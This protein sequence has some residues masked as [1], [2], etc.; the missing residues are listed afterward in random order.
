MYLAAF[1]RAPEKSGLDYWL[2]QI[3]SGKSFES[4]LETVFSLDIVKA[5]YPSAMT[6]QAFVTAIYANV[7]GRSP[8]QQGLNYWVSQLENKLGR[9]KLVMDMINAG[10]S[11]P[12]GTP[13]KAYIVNRLSVAEYAADQ[14]N[15]QQSDLSPIYLKSILSTVNADPASVT[16]AQK[17]LDPNV[18]G[19][20]LGAPLNALNVV[21]ASG[22]ISAPE[23]LAGVK[24]ILDLKGTNA[25]VG[26]IV[27][28]LIDKTSF[29]NPVS[30]ILNDAD[31]K[32][33]KVSVTIPAT[34]NWGADGLHTLSAY[35]KNS[36]GVQG[37]AGGDLVI[38]LNQ[39]APIAPR[40]PLELPAASKGING[41]EKAAGIQVKVDLA[42]TN[43]AVGDLLE[44]LI[45]GKSFSP[46]ATTVLKAS[47]V[48]AGV[49]STMIPLNAVWGADGSKVLEARIIDTSGNLGG[50][51]G[52]LTVT[53]DLTAPLPFKNVLQID[54]AVGGLSA[55]E[56]AADIAVVANLSGMN[57]IAGDS[58]ELLVD[59]KPFAVSTLHVLT[60]EEINANRAV[61]RIAGGDTAWGITD[62]TKVVTA[63]AIDAAGNTGVA[64]GDFKVVVDTQAP[65]SQNALIAI[66]A[67][68]NGLNAAEINAGVDVVVNLTG[69]NATAGDVVTLLLG[70]Q[71]IGSGLSTTL[72]ATQVSSKSVTLKIPSGTVWGVDG[73][74]LLT[75]TIRD[76]AG[77]TGSLGS[78]FNLIVDTVAP[79]K[80]GSAPVIAVSASNIN[81]A[82]KTAGVVANIDIASTG[83][84]VGDKV[85]ILLNG[86]TMTVPVLQTIQAEDLINGNVNVT[87][88]SAAGWGSDGSKTFTAR[89][90]DVA[91]NVGATSDSVVVN[92][93]TTAPS[94]PTA[95]LQVPANSGGGITPAERAAGVQVTVSLT[96]TSAVAG[97]QVE[98]LIG[99]AS[100]ATP[101][102]KSLTAA[103]V[104][105][106]SVT[107]TI[108]GRDGWGANG[109]KDLT[110][111]FID[112][113]GNPGTA[114]GKVTVNA[115]PPTPVSSPL[116]IAAAVGG[117]NPAEKAGG[118]IVTASLT[119]TNVQ[120]GDAIELLIDGK[121]FANSTLH[122]ISASEITAGVATLSITGGDTAWGTTDGDRTIAAR[123]IDL[124]G[125]VGL[126]GGSLK[127]TIDSVAP[128]S[129]NLA[130]TVPAAL[131]GLNAAELAAGVDVTVNL[132]GTNAA[133]G[134]V[135]TLLLGG[136]SFTPL[137]SVVLSAA[138]VTAKSAVV[139][140]PGLVSWGADGNKTLSAFIT[141]A[142]G[143]QGLPGGA[144][145]VSLDTGVPNAPSNPIIIPVASNSINVSEKQSGV[146]VLVDLTG[147]NAV[148]GDKVEVLIDGV[149]FTTPVVQTISATDI[150]N[151]TV[152][153][154]I[155]NTANWGSD[156][157]KLMSARVTDTVGNL[158]IANA[159]IGVGL[160]LTAPLAFKNVL[161]IDAAVGGLSAAEKAADIA[162]VANLSGMNL[163]AGDSLELL[164]D[165]KPFAV[166][167][168]HVLTAE[169]INANRAVL[170]IAGGDTAWGITDGTKVVT[171]RAIDAAG[172]T[173]VAGG[174]FKVVVD[175]Q[176]PASQNA[177]IA[178]AAAANGLNAAEIN[179]GVDVVVNL[180]GTNATAGDVVT[181]LLGG[182]P[183]GSGLSTTLTATQV[184]SK[185][186]TLKIP[187]GTVWGVD[188]SKL[189]TA[190]IRD[191]AGNTGS[192]GSEFN[193]IVDTVAPGKPGSAPVIAVSASNINAAEKTA[194][195]VAN[196]DIASTGALVGDKVEILLNGSTMTVP[197]LQ[198]IQAED[199]INGNVNVTIPSA[200]GWGSDGSKTFTARVIDVAGNVGA[201]SDSV[202]VNLDT[203]APSGPTATLQV[204]ANSGGGIT[205]AERAAG[206]Q[207]TVSLTGTSAVAGEQVEILIGGASFATPVIKSLTAAEVTAKS[208]TLTIGGRDGWGANGI[209]DLTAR[210][211]DASGNP[212]TASGKVTVNAVPPTPVSSPLQIA[213]AVGGINPAEKAGGMIVTA[214][215]TNTN[216]QAGDAI[217][218]LI[219]GKPFAN[220]TLHV[221]SASEI[222][223]GVATLSITG[224]D[225]AWGT[226]D[227]DRTIAARFIDLSGNVGL[228][229]GSLK[230]TID[231][232]APTSQNLALT[233]PAA[234]N[235]L[236]AAELAAGVDVT[237]NL[238]GTNAAAG[239][240]VTLLLGGASFTPLVSVVLSAAQV[241]AKSAVVNIPG[242]V[243]W[244]ADGNKTLSAF[245]TDAAGN[246]GLPGGAL[247][248]SL[249][250]GV[251]NAP[252]NPIIIPA[253]SNSI[254][255]SEKQSGVTVLVDLTG[256]N[257]VSGDK[258]EVLIG[259]IPFTTPVVQTITA[260]DINNH[261]V[262]IIIPNTANWGSD[263]IKL[264]SAR[265]LDLAGNLGATS[266]SLSVNL[267]LTAPNG[268]TMAL[269]VPSNSGGGI[270]PAERLAGVL[271][272]VDL[273]GTTAT[274]GDT[275]EIL[276]GGIPFATPVTHVLSMSDLVNHIVGLTIATNNSWG[277]DGNKILSARFIDSSG[278]VGTAAG[279]VTVNLDGTA[280]NPT[281]SSLTVAAA[282]NG[283]SNAEKT[284]GVIVVVDLNATG[285]IAGDSLSIQLDGLPFSTPVTQTISAA[286]I[287]AKSASIT[288]PSTAGWGADGNKILTAII[289][290]ALGNIGAGGGSLTVS[291]DTTAP[292][293]PS[294][295]ISIA[296]SS[297]GISSNEKTAGVAVVVDLAGTGALVGDKAEILIGGSS[298]PTAVLQS[299]S[300]S[301]ITNGNV[302][303]TIPSSAV[304]GSDGAKTIAARIVDFAGNDGVAGSGVVVTLDTTAPTPVAT[305]LVVAANS[306]GG[307][308]NAEKA[309]GVGV[310]IDLTGTGVVAGDQIEILLGGNPFS[311][312]VLHTITS[313]E[314]TAK[315]GSLTIASN[316]GWGNDGD[317][318]LTA[319]LIDIAGNVSAAAGSLTVTMQDTTAPN[320][321]VNA[322]Y[323]AVANG[324]ISLAEKNA[325]VTVTGY[326]AGTFAVAGDTAY[327]QID[328]AN[329]T[330]P[331]SHVLTSAEIT[332]GSFDFTVPT[333]AGWGLDGTHVLTMRISDV[334][335]N[336]G[337]AGGTLSVTLDTVAPTAPVSAVVAVAS[338]NGINAVEKAAGVAT[339]VSLSGTGAVTNDKVEL[340]LGGSAFTVPVIHTL[341]PAEILAGS[342][343]ITIDANAG[344][345]VDG[346]KTI[347]AR[348]IDVAGN[349]GVAGGS[350]TTF[351]E[352][353]LPAASGL[354]L[355]TDVDSSGTINVGD[356]YRFTIT[357][358]TNKAIGMANITVNSAHIFGTGATAVWSSDGTQLTLT[359]GTG[360]SIAIGDTIN[361]IGVSD[362]AGNSL[363]LAFTI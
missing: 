288:I 150:S 349:V 317:K 311:T 126:S 48:V 238:T 70:G 172:N 283:I 258:V 213:A 189:L 336:L 120:A 97:E 234:L 94:G 267:D 355:Y 279:A 153:L 57:L 58:L 183:I 190:T 2:F 257:A 354:P 310:D 100:F 226:T 209:K 346:V 124:S 47:D 135:V 80:P 353:S 259:G 295:A 111:R 166:S 71:P 243:S 32:A 164:V 46:S 60:A 119:N 141:D 210:F 36:A 83:A 229:G 327:L 275:L 262:N 145:S 181:L 165:G 302:T 359:L 162:V 251:P 284:S 23:V 137:V 237:V 348:M 6:N 255:V 254:N 320:A 276:I 265:V 331:V 74:K 212:G 29:P 30:Y 134:D 294:N 314:V 115:V 34:A 285:A 318:I 67:A 273:T 65:A 123:F 169:E 339:T 344:W 54:A 253:A 129:Q 113:S 55:A 173:G 356:T 286:Q 278:N 350:L 249:D 357:E 177:L 300:S 167:T 5:I 63:R 27:E 42:G 140:I 95:T 227:G 82:E 75:A 342:A 361:L 247:S 206:V 112:A 1:V 270:S 248:V 347:S 231:S 142:A 175:T 193:L 144:L 182:Q 77:N 15:A 266:A 61:L 239:D 274:V 161:Q 197:V 31:I 174:D 99:G 12:D 133:A 110:A 139:N 256:T 24:V 143:N 316:S 44:I 20:G 51:G 268:P 26:N 59:G 325:G 233:V 14:Q 272:N 218:L 49:V 186:V 121:P 50:I 207:V 191:A 79:G 328:G 269:Q 41:V 101:V 222:T 341:T 217:E 64:G 291:L 40:V 235:G 203:T 194:G 322:L 103:E 168:L 315:L 225:T 214:S 62:G 307:I 53:L 211:I 241:T 18:T 250:T 224:G 242:L 287:T 105:A 39:E 81:A 363:N 128:T 138:Q 184:S 358:A 147:T 68:A 171:A 158:G 154:I 345:G 8:D 202:V 109:I 192:L 11:T 232:V 292:L 4:V 277:S 86:S 240:V 301:D 304:W 309:A 324:G 321:P 246:Q 152:S 199:L 136:A 245:I 290:D 337:N 10:L 45:D 308:D 52:A 87:I 343:N 220:S 303:V 323:S 244:G 118:M 176:A 215:L 9:G 17:A 116:Q 107:L 329:F 90:I 148:S 208:V 185:S 149:P 204:P 362:P 335:G 299:I 3:N 157:I 84:L 106:K 223:A 196:I 200:A 19:V 252:S 313:S 180:T 89:V 216:V 221:I 160:D 122:V 280:P 261:L 114:S 151:R 306:G 117:I 127:V 230:V 37:K 28:L 188:G 104:T 332:A 178:I 38:N 33:Q 69:T 195:V 305:A 298:F 66:A 351:M 236:N 25:V 35:V 326:L 73:S 156:G 130:L 319:R 201:T 297:N 92:L 282:T 260:T 263:G 281:P 219:D 170:R 13:G 56:K 163:I 91:G 179:A 72:T 155:P 43:A 289:T 205:P 108:G 334:A 96:G 16:S 360:T 340:L 146:T 264:I 102:I 338:A 85:E 198:T 228:S 98:I 7:F 293:A 131:N 333:G 88:P 296:A 187:S 132:T 330:T 76:A 352:T 271:V 159:A 312:P 125:N 78:E 21:A 93:D 22:G